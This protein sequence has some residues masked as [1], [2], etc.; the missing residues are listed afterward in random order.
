MTR[1]I[2]GT[3]PLAPHPLSPAEVADLVRR[4]RI[5]M[6][7]ST[8]RRVATRPIRRSAMS[9]GR[10]AARYAHLVGCSLREAVEALGMRSTDRAL[11][12]WR[13]YYPGEE[14]PRCPW[15]HQSL[16]PRRPLAPINAVPQFPRDSTCAICTEPCVGDLHREPLGRAGALV[17]VC[18]RCATEQPVERDHL[19][20][21]GSSGIGEGNR[22]T[23][24]RRMR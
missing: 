19:F 9:I 10:V 18:V 13:R 20:G 16:G 15:A 23:Q 2:P 21:G 17:N 14:T 11:I 5:A 8:D 1:Y 7:K 12:W 6:V 3:D 4:T 24:S 22:H